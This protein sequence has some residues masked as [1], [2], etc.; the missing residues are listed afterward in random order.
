MSEPCSSYL[1]LKIK[2]RVQGVF[3]RQ[4]T[5]EKADSLGLYGF[6]R[7]ESDGSVF[8]EAFGPKDALEALLAWCWSGPPRARVESI[9]SSW[10][11]DRS[12]EGAVPADF[13]IK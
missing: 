6:V 2:G 3:Y 4:S 13:L 7:N 9:E 5:K 12:A 11:S 10:Q 1:T 8:L